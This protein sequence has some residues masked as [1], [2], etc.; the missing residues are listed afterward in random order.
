MAKYSYQE[1]FARLTKTFILLFVFL[2]FELL[3]ASDQFEAGDINHLNP[4]VQMAVRLFKTTTR[5]V[6]QLKDFLQ[7]RK[8]TKK[9]KKKKTIQMLV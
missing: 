7:K 4:P 3:A 2:S 1:F 5:K 8:G 9:E 6:S